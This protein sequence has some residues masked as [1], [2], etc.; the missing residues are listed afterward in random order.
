MPLQKYLQKSL[1]LRSV[2]RV[3]SGVIVIDYPPPKMYRSLTVTECWS[4]VHVHIHLLSLSLSVVW[5]SRRNKGNGQGEEEAHSFVKV[6][7]RFWL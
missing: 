5:V 3:V 2:G 7:M 4:A 1:K 6:S